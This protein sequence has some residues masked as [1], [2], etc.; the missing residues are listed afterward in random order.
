MPSATPVSVCADA[1]RSVNALALGR[2]SHVLCPFHPV[3]RH[4]GPFWYPKPSS[5]HVIMPVTGRQNPFFKHLNVLRGD[6]VRIGA[7][8][9]S[10]RNV[11]V[12]RDVY[13]H[14]SLWVRS[15]R[16]G[17]NELWICDPSAIPTIVNL[18]K[19]SSMYH[20]PHPLCYV[21]MVV[22]KRSSEHS[23]P[24]MSL[25]SVSSILRSTRTVGVPAL[26]D[27]APQR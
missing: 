26:G 4:P 24:R 27:L 14:Y 2:G 23:L 15:L 19:R 5:C 9:V 6:V 10:S 3:A 18:P 17:P 22:H 8:F 20:L 12:D 25:W 11:I 7:C 1:L 13:D 16:T 21:L